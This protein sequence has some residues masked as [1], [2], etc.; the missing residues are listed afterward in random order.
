VGRACRQFLNFKK[1][2]LDYTNNL[3]KKFDI[4][5]KCIRQRLLAACE[6]HHYV[7]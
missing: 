5:T 6:K 4:P 1:K 3:E 2:K 7:N